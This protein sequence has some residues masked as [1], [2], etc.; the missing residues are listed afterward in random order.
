M[1]SNFKTQRVILL[2][3]LLASA[4]ESGCTT[5]MVSRLHFPATDK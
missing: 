3:Y 2:S 4:I 5:R 1:L